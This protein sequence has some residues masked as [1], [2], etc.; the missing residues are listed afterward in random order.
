MA[1]YAESLK[2]LLLACESSSCSNVDQARQEAQLRKRLLEN[3][4][5]PEQNAVQWAKAKVNGTR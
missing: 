4:L 5:A 1:D 2:S 3:E